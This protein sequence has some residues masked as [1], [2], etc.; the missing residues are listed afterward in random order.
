MVADAL[1]RA[2]LPMIVNTEHAG[3]AHDADIWHRGELG[4]NRGN[5]VGSFAIAEH[6]TLRQQASAE[7]EIFFGENDSRSGA[8]SH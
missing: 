4:F 8:C 3:A 5:P 6:Q 1:H 7:P 2:I